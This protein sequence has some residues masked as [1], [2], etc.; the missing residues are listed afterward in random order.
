[1]ANNNNGTVGEY[2]AAGEPVNT[3]F[4]SGLAGPTFLA[5]VPAA[6]PSPQVTSIKSLANGQIELDGTGAANTVYNI[7]SSL[8]DPSATSFSFLDTVT[9]NGVGEWTFTEK[10]AGLPR[11]FYRIVLP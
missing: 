1:V 8:T 6:T 9:T 7:E 10:T 11:A 2:T 5:I 3:T 4:I